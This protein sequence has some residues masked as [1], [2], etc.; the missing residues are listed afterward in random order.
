MKILNRLLSLLGWFL[1]TLQVL[2]Y[3]T[4]LSGY[5]IFYPFYGPVWGL[6]AILYGIKNV[7]SMHISSGLSEF[8][9][10]NMF[11]LLGIIL[12]WRRSIGRGL[13]SISSIVVEKLSPWMENSQLGF[14]PLFKWLHIRSTGIQRLYVVLT[15]FSS[16]AVGIWFESEITLGFLWGFPLAFGAIVLVSRITIWIKE[17]FIKDSDS[18]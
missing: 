2:V 13:R 12:V 9:A 10:G 1:I 5:D 14:R 15:I 16:T 8:L 18:Q 17:G 4:Y 3:L 6:K 7:S 11:V